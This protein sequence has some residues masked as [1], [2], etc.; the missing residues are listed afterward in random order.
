MRLQSPRPCISTEGQR[1]DVAPCNPLNRTQYCIPS[2][3]MPMTLQRMHSKLCLVNTFREDLVC[4]SIFAYSCTYAADRLVHACMGRM[5]CSVNLG[6]SGQTSSCA[7]VWHMHTGARSWRHAAGRCTHA[8]N[9]TIRRR[10]TSWRC[11]ACRAWFVWPAAS[12]SP[13]EVRL[14]S[15]ASS[16]WST[17]WNGGDTPQEH[18]QRCCWRGHAILSLLQL[19]QTSCCLF[20][21]AAS[22]MRC[23]Q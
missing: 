23:G 13:L 17:S 16:S 8:R 18:S 12:A 20:N 14:C 4:G 19:H 7:K 2:A 22:C 15:H 10:I 3:C 6:V 9:A 1:H 21:S 11:R 5:I